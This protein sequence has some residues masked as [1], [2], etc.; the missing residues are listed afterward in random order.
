MLL[1]T[2]L[3]VYVYVDGELAPPAILA[4][5]QASLLPRLLGPSS[6][7]ML[8]PRQGHEIGRAHV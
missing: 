3:G 6:K 1:D 5:T 4:L 7:P 8:Q 2:K